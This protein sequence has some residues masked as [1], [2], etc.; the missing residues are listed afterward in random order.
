MTD[1]DT[2]T[3]D[4]INIGD[5]VQITVPDPDS[6]GSVRATG[7]VRRMNSISATTPAAVAA[8]WCFGVLDRSRSPS[9]P[10]SR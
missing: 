10:Y 3:R 6:Q 4:A 2:E 8:G 9:S 5:R 1:R 7:R